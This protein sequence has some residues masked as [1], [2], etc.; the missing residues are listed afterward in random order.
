MDAEEKDEIDEYGEE[1]EYYEEYTP[2]NANAD[3]AVP[4]N[5]SHIE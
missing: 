4:A 3:G 1:E 2:N 5:I